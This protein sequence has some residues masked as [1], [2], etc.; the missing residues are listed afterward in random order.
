MK[1]YL[2]KCNNC[3]SVLIDMNPQT[4]AVK[5][6]LPKGAKYMNYIWDK[7]DEMFFWAC[8]E[9]DTDEYLTDNIE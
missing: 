3:D 9:C 6:A 7:E 2:C 4:D 8:P 5:K 1:D